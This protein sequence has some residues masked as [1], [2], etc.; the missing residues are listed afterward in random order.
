MMRLNAERG[1]ALVITLLATMLLSALGVALVLTTIVETM[2]TANYRS[3]QE[4]LYAADAGLERSVQDLLRESNWAGILAGNVKSGF[5][6]NGGV[7]TLPDG[8]PANLTTLTTTLQA[9][10]DSVYGT[11]PNRPIWRLYAHA[12]ISNLIPG[13]DIASTAYIAVWVADDPAE[14]DGDP[15]RDS[16]GILFLHAEAFG[17]GGSRKVV[18]ATMFKSSAVGPE[19]GYAGQRGQDEQNRGVR[20]AAV[21][22]PG[23]PLGEMRMDLASGTM[24]SQ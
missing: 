3:A 19:T 5:V 16:N 23:R 7:T 2:I 6:D 17:E 20:T 13:G 15:S 8:T 14:A 1:T 12:P 11:E 4:A 18:E 24:G 22:T 21:Q 10:V 9:Q